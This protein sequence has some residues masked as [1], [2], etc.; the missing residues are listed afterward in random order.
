MVEYMAFMQC[1]EFKLQDSACQYPGEQTKKKINQSDSFLPNI[2]PAY[3]TV[4]Y[5]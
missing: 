5:F 3:K 1:V 2:E 4:I